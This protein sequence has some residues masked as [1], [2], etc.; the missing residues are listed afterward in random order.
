MSWYRFEKRRDY[1][2]D[3]C[4]QKQPLVYV[5]KVLNKRLDLCVE[6]MHK[7]DALAERCEREGLD[8]AE[9][10]GYG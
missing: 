8:S 9:T 3:G 7:M 2:C 4:D 10:W 5:M 6:C 1:R